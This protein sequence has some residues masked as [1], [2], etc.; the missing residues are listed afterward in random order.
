QQDSGATAAATAATSGAPNDSAS[1][2]LKLALADYKRVLI[3]RPAD[4]DAKWNYELALEKQKQS[5]GGGGGGGGQS[6]A[7]KAPSQNEPK[8]QATLAQ[9]QAEQLLGSAERQE[10]EGCST[11]Q[12]QKRPDSPRG[13]T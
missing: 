11:G 12:A 3:Q 7:S 4:L 9:R 8:P 5:G 6:N 13:G 1:G 2:Q 10:P